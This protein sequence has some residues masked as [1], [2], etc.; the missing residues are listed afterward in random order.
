LNK[1]I[2]IAFADITDF[3]EFG[4]V[5]RSERSPETGE[6]LLDDNFNPIT[7]KQGFV[8]FKESDVVDGGIITEVKLGRDGVVVKLADKMKALDFLT[9]HFEMNPD[10]AFTQR[11]QEERLAI[12]KARLT[13]E[14]DGQE[15]QDD[16]KDALLAVAERRKEM[17]ENE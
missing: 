17:R 7:Y 6:V 1:Y 4:S 15:T 11:I 8:D 5:D 2:Q 12:D 13:N 10:R 9:K 16:W 3:V 14:Q